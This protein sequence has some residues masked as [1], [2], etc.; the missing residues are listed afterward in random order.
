MGPWRSDLVAEHWVVFAGGDTGK[1]LLGIQ[2]K[3]TTLGAT[4]A[5]YR[6]IGGFS[7]QALQMNP[8]DGWCPVSVEPSS[9]FYFFAYLGF[10]LFSTTVK[11]L[12]FAG[13]LI[14]AKNL[15]PQQFLRL[16]K[17]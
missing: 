16:P 15:E 13:V 4:L 3:R 14:P 17:E 12:F 2:A 10:P 11:K 7:C 1:F 6:R 5:A 9:P 8:V